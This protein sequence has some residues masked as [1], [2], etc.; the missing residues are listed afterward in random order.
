MDVPKGHVPTIT[1]YFEMTERSLLLKQDAVPLELTRWQAPRPSEYLRLFRE[2]GEP[3]MWTSRVLMDED[4]LRA[5]IHDNA[6]EIWKIENEGVTVGLLELDF[7]TPKQC[8]IGFFGLVPSMNG[9]GYGRWLMTE[10]LEHAWRSGILRVWLHTCTEDS[11]SAI[12]FY[13]KSGFTAYKRAIEIHPDPRLSGHLP[14][15]AGPHIP[16]IN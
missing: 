9:K 1:T 11:P 2:V 16:I 14:M 13:I 3:W 4:E 12:P 5:I 8:E 6:V 10:A 7:R 15:T